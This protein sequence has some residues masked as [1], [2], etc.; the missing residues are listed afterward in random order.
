M[1]AIDH[2]DVLVVGAGPAGTSTA[3]NLAKRD[4]TWARRVMLVDAAI[5]PR[6]KLCGGGVTHL[7]EQVLARMGLAFAPP[8]IAI[9]EVRVRFGDRVARFRGDPVLRIVRRSLLDHWLLE[10]ARREGVRVREGKRVVAL[11]RHDD[12]VD[13]TTERSRLRAKVVVGADG[14]KSAVR[15]LLGWRDARHVARLLEVLTPPVGDERALF[16]DR[17]ASF[18]LGARHDRVHGYTWAFPT[19]V[20]ERALVSRGVYDCNLSSGPRASLR[21]VLSRAVA[22]RG[23][24]LE[25]LE[26]EGHP[27][28]VFDPRGRLATHRVLLA[29]DAAGADALFGEGISFALA[30]GEVAAEAV[31]RGFAARRFDFVE[32]RRLVERHALLG[33]LPWRTTLA[34][35]SGGVSPRT[36]AWLFEA[37]RRAL[38]FTRWSDPG[39]VP[40]RARHHVLRA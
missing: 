10:Q 12:W 30:Y 13:V 14:S 3:L 29:G 28:R 19:R 33:Q 31:A 2:V 20:G 22:A 32:Y 9:R 7:A 4:P 24:T 40:S 8:H 5:H 15:R 34:R 11:E 1:T 39:F 26:L 37:A 21:A 16:D 27:I 38:P 18:D 25:E 36:L 23:L 35:A 17:V 6:D